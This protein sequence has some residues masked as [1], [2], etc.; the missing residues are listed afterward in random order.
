MAAISPFQLLPEN[1][2]ASAHASDALSLFVL[3]VCGFFTLLI[4]VLI[5]W[6]SLRYRRRSED[7]V[8]E[9]I[10]GSTLLEIIWMVLP[11]GLLLIMFVWGSKLFLDM[12]RP[13]THAMQIDV[14]GK[15]WMWKV[16]HPGGQREIDALHVPTGVPVKLV[17]TSQDVIHDFYI[18]AFRIKQD[19][20]PGSFTTEWFIATKPGSYHL[21]C[22]EYCGT[23][24]SQMIGT[25]TVLTPEDYQSWLAGVAPDERPADA[26]ARLFV[27]YGCV[28]CHSKIAPTMAGLFGSK[29]KLSD[30]SMITADEDYLR[31]SILDPAAKVVAGYP[32]VMPSYSG[33][34]SEEQV[35]QLVAYI[36]ELST[37][38]SQ[39]ADHPDS[40]LPLYQL[41]NL[42]PAIRPPSRGQP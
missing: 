32:P 33:H 14:I 25:V 37:A 5:V 16:Q 30:G 2:S 42:P 12:R 29:V 23:S 18:P 13:P 27:S 35:F 38:A 1:A 22:S 15:Q 28:Q 24:H 31:E 8:P 41:P 17:M 20:L 19:V 10:E 3:A 7:E 39:P 21:F 40:Q 34:L 6:F 4:F 11:F 26:G 9:R 36:K